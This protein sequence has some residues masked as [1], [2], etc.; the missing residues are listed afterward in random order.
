MTRLVLDFRSV[1]DEVTDAVNWSLLSLSMMILF[2]ESCSLIRITF[3][4][5]CAYND[6]LLL[7]LRQATFFEL[8][9]QF[10]VH[11]KKMTCEIIF[12]M[13]ICSLLA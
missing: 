4:E 5:P 12:S 7:T 3:S 6:M 2:L 13:L 9:F 11:L 8:P 10:L 1:V